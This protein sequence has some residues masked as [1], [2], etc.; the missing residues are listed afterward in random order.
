[1]SRMLAAI[2][3]RNG[4]LPGSSGAAGARRFA[5]RFLALGLAGLGFAGLAGCVRPEVEKKIAFSEVEHAGWM[6]RGKA[7]IS[8]EGFLRRAD[9]SLA[10]CSGGVVYLVPAT[11]Y[12][13]EW[14]EVYHS[15]AR[16][17]NPKGLL[18]SH[19]KAIRKT[20]C[21]A[22]GRFTFSDLPKGKWLLVTRIAY[23]T[24]HQRR[25]ERDDSTLVTTV[26]T[27]VGETVKAILSNPNRI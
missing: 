13:Q 15:G 6:A 25:D 20:Q 24:R 8:G 14:V 19:G 3:D 11:P 4:F 27:R 2:A 5:R 16:I 21:D 18:E 26:E 9:A 10:R 12:F 7:E 22:T 23:E 17:A 1:L